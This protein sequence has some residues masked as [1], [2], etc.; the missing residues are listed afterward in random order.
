MPRE[1]DGVYWKNL[2]EKRTRGKTS[3]LVV[4]LNRVKRY[5][6]AQTNSPGFSLLL[7]EQFGIYP[8]VIV[9]DKKDDSEDD[10]GSEDDSVEEASGEDNFGG[11]NS[12]E[13]SG[14]EDDFV[15]EVSGSGTMDDPIVL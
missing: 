5:K 1:L 2:E 9:D 10:S 12:G 6:S 8:S 3:F 13:A 4:D 15:E 14:G 11:E 7:H